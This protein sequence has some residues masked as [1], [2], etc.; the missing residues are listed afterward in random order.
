MKKEKVVAAYIQELIDKWQPETETHTGY[1]YHGSSKGDEIT[2]LVYFNVMSGERTDRYSA[3]RGYVF[4]RI[5]DFIYK[6]KISL[7]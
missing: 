3:L 1:G 7:E 4:S 5:D 2:Y 6:N